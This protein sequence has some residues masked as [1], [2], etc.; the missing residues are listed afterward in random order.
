MRAVRLG[1]PGHPVEDADVPMPPC[2]P[3]DVLV[4]GL[5]VVDPVCLHYLVTCAGRR[6]DVLLGD[7]PARAPHRPP[8]GG[9]DGAG[10]RRR[11]LGDVGG[12][13]PPRPGRGPSAIDLPVDAYRD[14]IG[15]NDH[16][17]SELYE[18]VAMAD[19]GVLD[20]TD[21]VTHTVPLQVIDINGV[22]DALDRHQAPVRAVVVP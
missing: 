4:R 14:L 6:Q 19:A 8:H 5:R 1:A 2:G 17:L 15:S 22:L 12:A 9:R 7:L 21:V 3:R 10:G 13:T 20:L 18:L 16:L 11:R